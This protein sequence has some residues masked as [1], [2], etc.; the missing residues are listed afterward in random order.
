MLFYFTATG[1][2][3]FIADRIADAT[4]EQT[5]NITDCVQN[6][7][8]L[9]ELADGDTVGLVLP[10]YFYGIPIIAS[11]YLS[12]LTIRSQTPLYTYAV[13][14]CGGSTGDSARFIRKFLELDAVYGIK[15]TDNYVPMY[16]QKSIDV[17][18]AQLNA[19]EQTID[20]IITSINERTTGTHNL[21]AGRLP[22]LLTAVAYPMY[23]NGRK[24]RKFKVSEK[25][26]GCGLCEKICPRKIIS[27]KDN[28]PLWTVPRCEECLACLHRC[29]VAAIDYGKSADHGRYVNPRVEL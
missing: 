5:A 8:Y 27:C 29:P 11:E 22:R 9:F 18:E 21:V 4:S 23:K 28:K 14:N 3:K 26:N 15:V 19:A 24:T 20:K 2:S 7:R 25:C 1:N 6:N 12:K 10:V 13:L 17:I 16:K